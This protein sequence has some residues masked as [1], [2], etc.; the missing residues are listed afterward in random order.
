MGDGLE[1]GE[2]IATQKRRV[3]SMEVDKE[4]VISSEEYVA[5][6]TSWTLGEQ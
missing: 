6:P 2:F 3:D 1:E 4:F 5:G